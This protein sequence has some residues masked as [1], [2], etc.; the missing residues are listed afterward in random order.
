M[1]SDLRKLRNLVGLADCLQCDV[2]L[3]K[4]WQENKA[5][6]S[7]PLQIQR[8]TRSRRPRDVF[9]ITDDASLMMLKDLVVVLD[10]FLRA[11]FPGIYP[12]RFAHGYVKKR[13]AFTNAAIHVGAAKLMKVDIRDFFPS[14]DQH[15]VREALLPFE[16][17]DSGRDL[18]AELVTLD[19]TLP[20]GF[21]T[22]PLLSNIVLQQADERLA[23]I[24]DT[25]KCAYSR[26]ADDLSFSGGQLPSLSEIRSVLIDAGFSLAN[27]KTVLTKRGQK[28]VVTGYD[29][30]SESP[31]LPK[32]Q[33]HGLRQTAYYIAKFGVE[34]H[35]KYIGSSA[36]SESTRLQGRIDYLH[37]S[38]PHLAAKL[39]AKLSERASELEALT[40][41]HSRARARDKVIFIDETE[42]ENG[43]FAICAAV[44]DADSF[45]TKR[46]TEVRDRLFLDP[47]FAQ[48]KRDAATKNGLHYCDLPEDGRKEAVK[49]LASLTSLRI[50]ISYS[51][52]QI[53][54]PT[55]KQDLHERLLVA[56]FRHR[57]KEH[58]HG[59]VSFLVENTSYLSV[60]PL[61]A[62]LAIQYNRLP[63]DKRCSELPSL[64]L[65]KKLDDV[66]TCL[67]DIA[68]GAWRRYADSKRDED[69]ESLRYRTIQ[70]KVST[71]YNDDTGVMHAK[72]NPFVPF[73][74]AAAEERGAGR[75]ELGS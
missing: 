21:P 25:F 16:I 9:A 13:S 4:S 37:A 19:G 60:A 65:I 61:L 11:I 17:P 22:S 44:V 58:H 23:A 73:R 45:A 31:R 75:N 2:D 27:D 53:L 66:R 26:Y 47:G 5:S 8:R 49:L 42:T 57:M 40:Q 63:A 12:S 20:I 41:W 39:R 48:E 50:H 34:G 69:L 18:L 6:F 51:R 35:S 38:Q 3:L 15:K 30:T 56:M 1:P 74:V 24:A 62:H 67:P 10:E 32:I 36:Q 71:L 28:M 29:I 52:K 54:S 64:A 46:V 33:R 59:R 14:I 72:R 43:A 55:Q 68:L 7:R 70:R